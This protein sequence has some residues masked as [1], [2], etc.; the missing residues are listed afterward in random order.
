[1]EN[2]TIRI[3]CASLYQ[4]FL[5]K[6]TT[7]CKNILYSDVG[8]SFTKRLLYKN[9]SYPL[10]L[11]IFEG[12][13]KLGYFDSSLFE[14]GISKKLLHTSEDLIR[15]IIQHEIAHLLTFLEYGDGVA[16]HGAEF[17]AVCAR[18]GWKNSM[19]ATLEESLLDEKLGKTQSKIFKLF[20]L[21][22]SNNPFE[23]KSALTKARE[24]M[25]KHNLH[26]MAQDDDDFVIAR[27]LDAKKSSEK[28]RAISLILREF[29][30]Y[31][32]IN[33][34]L[35]KVYL[36]IFGERRHIEI[37]EYLAHLLDHK[38]DDLWKQQTSLSGVRAKNS[39]F[40]GIAEGFIKGLNCPSSE[41]AIIKIEKNLQE[42]A[43]S[44]YPRLSRTSRSSQV[45][46]HALTKGRSEGSH[47][48]LP[49]GIK[50]QQENDIFALQNKLSS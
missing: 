12:G 14:I 21:A 18:Y 9:C 50:K 3:L 45:D 28:M 38:L 13:K 26:S 6:C 16:H 30:V 17:R 46:P 33:C 10:H 15:E 19:K 23:A 48:R 31:P 25:I 1:M 43:R 32:V 41:H 2:N 27:V 7:H 8:L 40:K 35:G 24:L 29:F 36:E 5:R 37:G 34:G 47:L 49:K 39:F 20:D 22:S 44:A 42:R 11:V 4:Q